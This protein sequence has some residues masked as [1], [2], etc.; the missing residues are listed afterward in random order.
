MRGLILHRKN[1]GQ[2]AGWKPF[3]F[4]MAVEIIIAKIRITADMMPDTGVHLS[5]LKIVGRDEVANFLV[6]C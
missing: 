4:V 2:N 6:T 5:D 1:K 3:A